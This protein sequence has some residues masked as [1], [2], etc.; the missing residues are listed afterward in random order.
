MNLGSCAAINW[1]YFSLQKSSRGWHTACS[2]SRQPRRPAAQQKDA[3]AKEA[4]MTTKRITRRAQESR[5]AQLLDGTASLALVSQLTARIAR[6]EG[7]MKYRASDRW[8]KQ[9][10]KMLPPAA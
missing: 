10:G 3:T 5:I 6:R 8:A 1:N 9:E 7:R 2:F 4:G